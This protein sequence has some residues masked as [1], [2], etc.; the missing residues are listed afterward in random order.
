MSSQ[1]TD[2]PA[3]LHR[4]AGVLGILAFDTSSHITAVAVCVGDRVLAANEAQTEERHA[5]ILLPKLQQCLAQ[6]GLALSDIDLIGV[7]VGPGSFTGVR[8]G[9]ATAKGLGLALRKPVV[10][11]ISLEALAWEAFAQTECDLVAS[12]LDAF[13]GELFAALYRRGPAGPEV[14]QTP[15]HAVPSEVAERLAAISG[16]ERVAI[17]GPGVQRYPEFAAALPPHMQPEMPSLIAPAARVIAA[18][19][20]RAHARGDVPDLARV[21][22]VYLRDSDAQLPKQPLRL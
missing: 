4:P 10:P 13:K 2:S 15:F 8:V 17:V 20:A 18:M 19:A 6:A 5:E 9:V 21:A 16:H 22:P 7:G 1:F 3:V 11:V 12:C 14:V